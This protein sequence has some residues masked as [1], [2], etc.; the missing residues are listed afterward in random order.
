[1][2]FDL[3]KA[4]LILERT[5]I[6]LEH[7]LQNLPA[8]LTHQNEGGDSWSPYDV[9]GHLIHGE[10]TDWLVRTEIIL[11]GNNGGKFEPFDRYAQLSY[12]KDKPLEDLLSEFQR[13]RKENLQLLKSKQLSTQDFKKTG[14]HPELG[15]VTLAQ[16][17]AS[18]V[19]HDLGHITQVSRVMAKQYKTGVGPWAKYLSILNSTPQENT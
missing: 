13:L 10:K 4:M 2:E 8:E 1:M 14:E 9:L 17:L 19:V 5:P 6:V 7:L 11:K 16:L 12:S 18:W 3:D 15:L